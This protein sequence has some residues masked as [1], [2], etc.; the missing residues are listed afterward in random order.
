MG[1]ITHQY[2]VSAE[3][4]SGAIWQEESPWWCWAG[5]GCT[6][7]CAGLRIDHAWEKNQNALQVGNA[8]LRQNGSNDKCI[9]YGK[10]ANRASDLGMI[11]FWIFEHGM[12]WV[13]QLKDVP[14]SISDYHLSP[15][16]F[17]PNAQFQTIDYKLLC[18]CLFLCCP[19]VLEDLEVPICDQNPI[20]LSAE[21]LMFT[22]SEHIKD[23]ICRS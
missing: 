13:P 23:I 8:E 2:L 4:L 12:D 18:L 11:G 21:D 19:K 15:Q 16:S 10:D 5:G 22:L 7:I 6:V 3:G 20:V 9:A 17:C 14:V 1:L